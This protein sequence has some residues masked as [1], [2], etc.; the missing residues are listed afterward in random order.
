MCQS[1]ECSLITMHE[2]NSAHFH[3]FC[4]LVKC[5]SRA[6]CVHYDSMT[7][8]DVKGFIDQGYIHDARL[9]KPQEILWLAYSFRGLFYP[10]AQVKSRYE[11]TKLKQDFCFIT[12]PAT[13]FEQSF[14]P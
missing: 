11:S 3:L 8:N 7:I 6:G 14:L 10:I 9:K 13:A 5:F 12:S 1:L 4:Q 2:K